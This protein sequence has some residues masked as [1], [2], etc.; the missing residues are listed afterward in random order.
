MYSISDQKLYFK[1][2]ILITLRKFFDGMKNI[3]IKLFPQDFSSP[4]ISFICRAKNKSLILY[5]TYIRDGL[6]FDC[7]KARTF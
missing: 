2:S 6:G 3:I 4:N 7:D 5:N 1:S